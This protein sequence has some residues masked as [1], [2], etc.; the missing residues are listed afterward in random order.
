M[1][2]IDKL[3]KD[4]LPDLAALYDNAFE[5]SSNSSELMHLIYNRI[6]SDPCYIVLCARIDNKVVGSVMGVVC[7]ELFGICKPF[8]VVENVA[9]HSQYRRL[10]IAKRLMVRL[11]TEAKE[12]QC[13]TMLFVSSAHRA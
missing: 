12:N 8:M 7:Y 11:E 5:S 10:G 3:R 2:T 13:T 4:D 1:I 6:A 9:V